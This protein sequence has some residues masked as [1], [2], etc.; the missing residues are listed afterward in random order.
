MTSPADEFETERLLIRRLRDRDLRA[1]YEI[2]TSNPTYLELT[3]GSRGE[4]GY[5]DMEMFKRDYIVAQL[6]EDRHM[7]GI[8]LKS[9]EPV[10]LLDWI[11][12]NPSDGKPW[13]GL[14]MVLAERQREGIGSEAME[15]LAQTLRAQGSKSVRAGVIERNVIGRAFAERNG[16]RHIATRATRMASVEAVLI[17]ERA[18]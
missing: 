15:G 18:L 3:E 12:K 11:T 14:V 1:A 17:M 5:Y 9:G 10:G 4:P 8:F 7:D 16:F 13:I 6:S 2:Y